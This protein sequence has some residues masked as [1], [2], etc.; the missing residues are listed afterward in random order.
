LAGSVFLQDPHEQGYASFCVQRL[1]A[2]T[3]R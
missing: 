1:L 2:K 3:R